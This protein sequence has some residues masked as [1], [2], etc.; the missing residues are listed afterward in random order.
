MLVWPQ[1][2]K[3]LL[4]GSLKCGK[5]LTSRATKNQV[6]ILACARREIH[7]SKENLRDQTAKTTLDTNGQVNTWL[8]NNSHLDVT[9]SH[10]TA[11]WL[12]PLTSQY[13]FLS[14]T[15]ITLVNLNNKQ[16]SNLVW[17]KGF[18]EYS[19]EMYWDRKVILEHRTS[20]HAFETL[21]STSLILVLSL[22][23]MKLTI[24]GLYI[25]RHSFL[26]LR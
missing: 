13:N 19:D 1:Q 25:S 8:G 20:F 14:L 18:T 15:K 2:I 22:Y 21:Q 10:T 4:F 12:W 16:A 7:K 24:R 6:H 9:C 5:G 3:V 23:M 11:L 17:P 26:C